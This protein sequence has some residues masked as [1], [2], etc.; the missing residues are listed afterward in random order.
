[1]NAA[2]IPA[3]GLEIYALRSTFH[4]ALAIPETLNNPFYIGAYRRA[5]S[6]GDY[7]ILDNGA[8]EGQIAPDKVLLD[9]A[10]LLRANEIVAPDMI[11][12]GPATIVRTKSFCYQ[13]AEDL[14]GFKL[15]AVAQGNSLAGFRTCIDNLARISKV[16]VIGLPRHAI[17]TLESKAAR[18]DL[19]NWIREAYPLRF[20]IHLLGTN[21]KWLHEIKSAATYAPHIRSVDSAL[22]FNYTISHTKL[23]TTNKALTRH[24]RF[25]TY[26]WSRDVPANLLRDNIQTFMEWAG[27]KVG[28]KAAS[29]SGV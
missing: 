14:A 19:A 23:A 7:I 5:A 9:A 6:R 22:A 27:A 21:P 25:F 24:P 2:L 26:D 4:L 1:M 13:Y 28:T 18:I 16:K 12:D 20:G 29:S 3:R 15:M 17:D 10:R 8:A 11:K